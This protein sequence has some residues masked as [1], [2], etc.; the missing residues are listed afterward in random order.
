MTTPDNS[1][2]PDYASFMRLDG[3]NL[4][5]IGAGQGMGRQTSHALH[6]A[7]ARVVCVDIIESLA[8]EIAF[9]VNGIAFTG[10]MTVEAEVARM[11]TEV[12]AA[13]GGPIHGFVDI[14]GIAAWVEIIDMDESVWDSQFDLCLRH[15]FLLSKH[16]GRHMKEAG[17]GGTM[18][19]IASVHGISASIR[20]APYGAA[21]AGLMSLVKTI[22][23]EMGKYGI[24]ANAVAPGSILT[25]RM[26]IAL[27]EEAKR[28]AAESSVLS[29][30]GRTS[31][32]AS[33]ALFLTSEL[34]S[35]MTGQTII[36]DGGAVTADPYRTLL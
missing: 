24:R 36:V 1:P 23:H 14:V 15:A 29:R 22:A 13:L 32:I 30:I 25:P 21:K 31:D 11:V 10:D 12:S 18:V 9:E 27:S 26:E 19:F 7:G 8:N 3:R 2:I 34:S 17:E 33:A 16:V 4:V 35:F 6:Q 20:H 5:V 28:S